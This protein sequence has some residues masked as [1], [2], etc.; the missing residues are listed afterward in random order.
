MSR[1]KSGAKVRARIRKADT[2][3]IVNKI[4]HVGNNDRNKKRTIRQN[5]KSKHQA[6]IINNP[7]YKKLKFGSLNVNGI[8]DQTDEAVREIILKRELDVS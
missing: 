7:I 8:D 2:K 4:I 1:K 3:Q 6:P 5:M